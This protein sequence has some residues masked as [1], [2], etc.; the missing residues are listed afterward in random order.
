MS[1]VHVALLEMPIHGMARDWPYFRRIA[2]SIAAI[3]AANQVH[4]LD[5]GRQGGLHLSGW[6]EVR[7]IM[8]KVG[9]RYLERMI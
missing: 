9:S 4:Y 2:A 1:A 8:A 6:Y 5:K 3:A 7:G